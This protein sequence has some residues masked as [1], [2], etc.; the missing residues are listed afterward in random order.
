LLFSLLG[1]TAGPQT[2]ATSSSAPAAPAGKYTKPPEMTIDVNKKYT[3]T[4]QTDKGDIVIELLPKEAPITVNN[5]VFLARDGFFN[6][7][8]FHRVISNFVAQAGDPTG[9]STGG[10]GYTIEDEKNSLKMDT[11]AVAM[12]KGN[13]PNTAGSQF[14]ILLSPQHQMEGYYTIF[15][16]VTK[17][18]VVAASLTPRDPLKNPTV[19]TKGDL[20]NKVTIEESN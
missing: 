18:M 20:I 6:G 7:L 9:M 1:C 12:A 2:T 11:G 15:G 13:A 5:F 17:G 10:P 4:I 8:T 19:T 14:F 16:R 3:A